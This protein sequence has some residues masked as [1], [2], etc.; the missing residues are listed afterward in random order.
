MGEKQVEVD[1]RLVRN[2]IVRLE[3]KVSTRSKWRARRSSG[4]VPEAPAHVAVLDSFA[5]SSDWCGTFRWY[6][7]WPLPAIGC[8]SVETL[9][10][11]DTIIMQLAAFARSWLFFERA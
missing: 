5:A 3:R 10:A 11:N 1:R 4:S 8:P 6:T 2:R 9:F 7:S